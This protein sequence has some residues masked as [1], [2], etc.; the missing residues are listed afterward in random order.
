MKIFLLFN[1]LFIIGDHVADIVLMI[2]LFQHNQEWF[3]AIYLGADVFPA[4]VIMW[5][6]YQKENS[7]EALVNCL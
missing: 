6:K 5:S 1:M 2:Y 4:V 7:W 3:A